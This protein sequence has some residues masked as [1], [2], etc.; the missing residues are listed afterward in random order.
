[1]RSAPV[2]LVPGDQ[3][4]IGLGLESLVGAVLDRKGHGPLRIAVD[5]MWGIDWE[6]IEAAF[7]KECAQRGY[8]LRSWSTLRALRGPDELLAA[9]RGW[10]TDNPTFG[11]V[12]DQ[13]LEEYFHPSVL[14]RLAQGFAGDGDVILV[15]G[16]H[17]I[18]PATG[19]ADVRVYGDLPREDII[20]GQATL[21]T[22]GFSAP[23]HDPYKIAYYV[24]WPLLES[25][26]RG[27]LPNVDFYASFH[28][29][30]VRWVHGA[31]LRELVRAVSRQPF[32]CNPFFMPG[33]WG[34]HRLQQAAGIGA[35]WKNCAWDF[36][37]V[38]P[39]SSITIGRGES[40]I[41]VPF[42]LL[43][44]Q[45][46]RAIIGERGFL[47]FGEYF[48]IRF[49][50][51]DTM[52]GTNLSCQVHPDA[53]YIH[54]RFGEPIAQHE[55]YYIVE[56]RPGA[57][58]YLGFREGTTREAFSTAV[59]AAEDGVPMEVDA[60]VQS[61]PSRPGDYFLIP[62]GTV[63]CSGADNLVLEVSSTPYWYTFKLYD[64]LRPD[65]TG[66][67][68]PISTAFGLDVLDFR[69]DAPWVRS[70]LLPE[71]AVVRQEPGGREVHVGSSDLT[72][73]GC[74]RME[75]DRTM[76]DATRGSVHILAV[77]GGPAVDIV[78]EA[79]P[80]MRIRAEYLETF[81]VPEAFGA[82]RLEAVGDPCQILKAYIKQ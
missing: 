65:L 40:T 69:R 2:N 68:R 6:Q 36:E 66:K 54:E 23:G 62:A 52:G 21:G 59:R 71:P 63:H 30:Q 37:I 7:R 77:I 35:D 10:L 82:Y 12:C 57:R 67:P 75:I 3:D 73:Y 58:V 13:P 70:R 53:A 31:T 27:V 60:F 32:R 78:S 41:T 55:S 48:P 38:A 20:A 43:M 1:M 5:G 15:H 39:E 22:M 61:W 50:Y 24:E 18:G 72:F 46:G 8:G 42:R 26:Q 74:N 56:S 80:G 76:R 47:Y 44:W 25:H 11:R 64:Y 19:G 14:R 29:G 4:A 17:A 9:F 79:D 81:V 16:P 45:Q 51:L 28:G 33:V 49:N 34:G